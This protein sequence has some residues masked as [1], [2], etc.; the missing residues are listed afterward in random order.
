MISRIVGFVIIVVF[1]C[2]TILISIKIPL[3]VENVIFNEDLVRI[4]KA[5]EEGPF[6][7]TNVTLAPSNKNGYRVEVI[8]T[9]ESYPVHFDFW[10]LNETEYE[11][12]VKFVDLL[13][14]NYPNDPPFAQL[15]WQAKEIN[16]KGSRRFDLI[17]LHQDG[18]YV[19]I[20]VNFWDFDQY[21]RIT[22]KEHYQVGEKIIIEP[23]LEVVLTITT[24][25]LVGTV[26]VIVN[27]R[28]RKR[29]AQRKYK[30]K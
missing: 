6:H 3:F 7:H 4:P 15:V 24:L 13:I 25:G 27:I 18:R 30:L 26:L 2:L 10:I 12:F 23:N 11:W 21:V 17:N 22:I 28:K 14:E 5:I 20:F 1:L 9:P 29:T 8:L 16:I 19:I